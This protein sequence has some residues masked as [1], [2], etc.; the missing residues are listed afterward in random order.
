MSSLAVLVVDDSPTM[1]KM[2]MA[3]LG[4]LEAT[5]GEATNGLEALEQLAISHYDV[6][7]LD[8]NMPDM[9]GLEVLAHT[10]A[11]EQYRELPILVL[12]TRNDAETRQAALAAGANH[13]QTKP[14]APPVLLNVV[15]ELLAQRS[16]PA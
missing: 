15:E 6:M 8:M 12:T 10:R 2:V 1:R 14:F 4:P 9:H 16:P 11:L 5:F 13:Y 3:A 7:V